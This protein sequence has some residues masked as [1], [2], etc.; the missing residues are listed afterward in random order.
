MLIHTRKLKEKMKKMEI[1]DEEL[2]QENEHLHTQN[3]RIQR[4]NMKLKRQVSELMKSH[5]CKSLQVESLKGAATSSILD[6]LMHREQQVDKR[7]STAMSET[8]VECS[9]SSQLQQQQQGF[10]DGNQSTATSSNLPAHHRDTT[11]V[12]HSQTLPTSTATSGSP[13][14]PK[15]TTKQRLE[16]AETAV[17]KQGMMIEALERSLASQRGRFMREIDT[18]RAQAENAVQEQKRLE[19]ELD[20]R[21]RFGRNQVT[22][23]SLLYYTNAIVLVLYKILYIITI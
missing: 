9:S 23:F 7:E 19:V 2:S 12:V 15:L 22:A 10:A 11:K 4:K 18:L 8:S 6:E 20:K 21:E 3:S 13:T 16:Q 17:R 1:K 5:A 14:G